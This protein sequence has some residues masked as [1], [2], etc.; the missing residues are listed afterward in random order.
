MLDS[1]DKYTLNNYI[2]VVATLLGAF[3]GFPEPPKMFKELTKHD[4]VKWFLV[5]VLLYQGGAGQDIQL[6]A[7]ITGIAYLLY[8]FVL[9]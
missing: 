8:K 2:L 5:F 1:L 7:M 4:M 9:N 6:A 3:G